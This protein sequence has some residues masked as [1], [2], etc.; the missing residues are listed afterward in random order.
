MTAV[1]GRIALRSGRELSFEAVE[2]LETDALSFHVV[3][4]TPTG[5]RYEVRVPVAA[6]GV[7]RLA[8]EDFARRAGTVKP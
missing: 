2:N 4:V 7:M 8:L 5:R 3:S 1:L 6:V